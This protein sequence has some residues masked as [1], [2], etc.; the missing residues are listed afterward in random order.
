MWCPLH[1]CRLT[2]VTIQ[3]CQ[4]RKMQPLFCHNGR[5]S[6]TGHILHGKTGTKPTAAT[7]GAAEAVQADATAATKE[8]LGLFEQIH[9]WPGPLKKGH[10]CGRVQPLQ[11]DKQQ[12]AAGA[13]CRQ[14]ESS[15]VE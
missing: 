1:S 4:V 6:Q 9:Y 10:I 15:T 11:A 13:G 2:R 14:Q 5:R 8:D 12:Y 7:T 3:V